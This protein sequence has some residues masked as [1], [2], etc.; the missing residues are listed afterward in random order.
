MV[1]FL[2]FF[3]RSVKNS[4]LFISLSAMLMK[5]LKFYRIVNFFKTIMMLMEEYSGK[6]KCPRTEEMFEY[7][8]LQKVFVL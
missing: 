8:E 6:I 4:Q 3:Q 5:K 2:N 7:N 1:L